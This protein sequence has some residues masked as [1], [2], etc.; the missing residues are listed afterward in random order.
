MHKNVFLISIS[1]VILLSSC[2]FFQNINQ[3]SKS[4]PNDII[5]V[6]LHTTTEGTAYE[7]HAPFFGVCL[8]VGWTIPGD[9]IPCSGVYNE[10]IYYDDSLSIAQNGASPAPSGYYWWAGK[11]VGVSTESGNV[12]AVL[13]I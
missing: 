8:P 12:Y 5:T 11:G 10:V 4:L 13:S 2:I 1:I 9:S 3:P 6:S 7:I